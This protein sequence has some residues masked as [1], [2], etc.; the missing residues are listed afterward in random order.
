MIL[1]ALEHFWQ[2]FANLL[3]ILHSTR[4]RT[5]YFVM[6]S[7]GMGTQ[8]DWP[9]GHVVPH[10]STPWNSVSAGKTSFLSHADLCKTCFL[11]QKQ[12]IA[13][14]CDIKDQRNKISKKESQELKTQIFWPRSDLLVVPR[15]QFCLGQ[16]CT[17]DLSRLQSVWASTADLPHHVSWLRVMRT[18]WFKRKQQIL[19]PD[20]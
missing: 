11:F 10:A 3:H 13:S 17:C 7:F 6:A 19:Q 14:A 9:F 4:F 12:H 18:I 5:F 2:F 1:P 15:Y 20:M 8:F 16:P